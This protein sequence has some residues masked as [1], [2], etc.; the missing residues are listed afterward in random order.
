MEEPRGAGALE[1]WT[2][3][4]PWLAD[5]ALALVLG[6]V[7]LPAS[8]DVVLRAHW[9]AGA[10]A[11][12]VVVLALLHVGVALRRVSPGV[13]YVAG[14]VGMLVLVAVPDVSA[15]ALGSSYGTAVP[16]V[17][18]P[19]SLVFSVLLYSV[20]AS[21]PAV[22]A[23]RAL[24]IGAVGALLT[25]VR[26]WNVDVAAVDDLGSLKWRGHLVVAVAAAVAVPWALGRL[27]F[28]RARYDD[29]L[30]ERARRDERTH[31]ARELHDVVSHSLAVMVSQAEG[32]RMMASRDPSVVVPALEN[33]A[34]TGQEA[35]LGMRGLLDALDPDTADRAPSPTLAD[36]TGLLAEAEAAGLRVQ[37][38]IE[39]DVAAS[40]AVE[41][42]LHRVVQE[43]LTNVLKHAGPGTDVTVTLSGGD[44]AVTVEVADDGGPAI[45]AP[46]GRGLTGMQERVRAVGG[47]LETGAGPH[48]FVVRAAVP[49]RGGAS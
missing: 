24:A 33:V 4:R 32:A 30:A 1:A 26:L 5:A 46:A 13:V 37:H 27:R 22:D 8:L 2:R 44:D 19:S 29:A 28:V 35:L 43:A 20:A 3:P 14:C 38:R 9:P 10:R 25:I 21:R 18:V 15:E 12:V 40:P 34:R 31:I 45:P 36:L 39:P 11:A 7:L 23:A 6:A 41:L 47:T 17:L 16:V 48:G 49:T 42:V